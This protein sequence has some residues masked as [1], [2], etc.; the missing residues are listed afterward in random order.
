MDEQAFLEQK[1]QAYYFYL[2]IFP[3]FSDLVSGSEIHPSKLFEFFEMARFDVLSRFQSSAQISEE[4]LLRTRQA[5]YVVAKADFNQLHPWHGRGRMTI[6]TRLTVN[7][8]PM[9]EFSHR[10][11]DESRAVCAEATV[12]IAAVDEEFHLFQ[13]WERSICGQMS[14]FIITKGEIAT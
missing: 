14:R 13:D 6:Q 12:K 11:L 9:M 1:R 2:D 10:V 3:R 4:N 5:Q 8:I 7:N